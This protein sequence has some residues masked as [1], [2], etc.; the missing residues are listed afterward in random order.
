MNVKMN[1]KRPE[2]ELKELKEHFRDNHSVKDFKLRRLLKYK[3]TVL[4]V[5]R[6]KTTLKSCIN[7]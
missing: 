4:G 1:F 2:S 6:F 7:I 3:N 5:L